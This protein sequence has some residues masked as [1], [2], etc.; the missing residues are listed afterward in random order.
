M[1]VSAL[2]APAGARIDPVDEADLIRIIDEE[3]RSGITFENDDEGDSRSDALDYYDGTMSDLKAEKGRSSV[4]SRDVAEIVDAMQPGLMRIFAGAGRLGVYQP[5]R[6]GDEEIARQATEYVNYVFERDCNGY[7]VIYTWIMDALQVRNGVVKAYWDTSVEYEVEQETGLSAEQITMLF[8]DGEIAPEDI[9]GVTPRQEMLP[10]PD[11]QPMA[12]ELF[13]VRFRRVSSNGRMRVE[14]VPPEDFGISAK[15]TSIEGASC[16][17]HT[18]RM[19]RSELIKQ[20]YDAGLVGSLPAWDRP[21]RESDAERNRRRD[22]VTASSRGDG[23][24]QEIEIV[25]AYLYADCDGDGIA[26][27]R[28]VVL[29]GQHGGRKVLENVEWPDD[30]PFV[31]ITPQPVPHRWMGKSIAD[32]VMDLQRVKTALWRAALDNTYAQ[33]FPDREV[34]EKEI[35]DPDEVLSK[36]FGHIIRVKTPG[37]I[38][39]LTVPFVAQNTM[40]AIQAVDS[41]IARRTGVSQATQALDA[42]ALDPQTATA[43][44]LEH[45]ASYA[46]TEL[47]AR[48]MAETGLKRLFSKMLRI[49]VRNQDRP[50][51]IRLRDKWVDFDPRVW[52]AGMDVSVNI[53]LGT[54]SRERDLGMLMQVLR[55]QM[56][57]FE[58][59]GPDN[60]VVTPSM[61]V[62]TQQKIVEAAGLRDADTYFKDISDEEFGQWQ[63]SKPPPPPDPKVEA[64][65]ARIQADQQRMQAQLQMRREGQQADMAMDR[66]EAVAKLQIERERLQQEYALKVEELNREFA[67]RQEE[68]ARETELRATQVAM[69]VGGVSVN[70]PR[71]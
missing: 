2:P 44:Q 5:T 57:V 51:T 20:G 12:V 13:D 21:P 24:M 23:A 15:A 11:G 50:R 65:Q 71:Q 70:I 48:N 25:E 35:V 17:W 10:G 22:E 4:V 7:I 6:P 32:N 41:L 53:G 40:A 52:N 66:E 68:M 14:N 19:T 27:S 56:E 54:G 34:V 36:E 55:M 8:S 49:M 61:I 38:R 58:K 1:A 64:L 18:T 63:A 31:G 9:L 33:N 16:V 62:A 30:R 60:P 26:E 69:G 43:E 47:V 59:L 3:L 46:R 67:L 37:A 29:A 28:K 39:D 45:D 42:T